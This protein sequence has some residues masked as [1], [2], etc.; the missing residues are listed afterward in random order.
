MAVNNRKSRVMSR[1]FVL[2]PEFNDKNN[3]VFVSRSALTNFQ[4]SVK[5]LMC[6]D[7]IYIVY[8]AYLEMHVED[9]CNTHVVTS[10]T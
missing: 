5:W 9:K 2:G 3:S 8:E 4:V 10:I 6:P 7:I 1:P